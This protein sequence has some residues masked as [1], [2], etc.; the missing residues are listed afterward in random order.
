MKKVTVILSQVVDN[1]RKTDNFTI[2]LVGEEQ[3]FS[4]RTFR[5]LFARCANNVLAIEGSK[6]AISKGRKFNLS[7]T[8]G[9][10]ELSS[11][12][13]FYNSSQAARDRFNKALES[14]L[15]A[16]IIDIK[17]ALAQ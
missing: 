11:Y 12:T 7:I 4:A 2:S 9:E 16:A 3:N 8:L 14:R 6:L 10:V 1:E 5:K 13:T 15:N 17:D